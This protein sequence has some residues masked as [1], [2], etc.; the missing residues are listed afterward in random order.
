MPTID[1]N[2]ACPCGSG[3]VFS[4]CC[5]PYLTGKKT[6]AT[7]ELL[8][9]SR[10]SAF[11]TGNVDY[12]LDTHHPETRAQIKR[13]EVEDWSKNSDWRGL[14]IGGS[15]RGQATD[16]DG[17]IEFIAEYL[18]EGRVV[19]HREKSEFRKH[20]GKWYFYDV[21]KAKPIKHEVAPPGR[22]DACP[23]GSGKKY[24]K[25]CAA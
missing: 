25:C 7:A 20:D 21:Y 22:N 12:I 16:E 18:Q 13:E 23:C 11:V 15:D 1:S 4:K 3:E 2:K 19:D 17:V 10:Y 24:K 14:K 5:E 9:R 6:P 8:L